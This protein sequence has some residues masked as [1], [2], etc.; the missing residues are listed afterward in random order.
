[1]FSQ[2]K[3]YCDG[4]L[5]VY[6]DDLECVIPF[7]ELTV[8]P[9]TLSQGTSIFARLTAVNEI[10]ESVPSDAGNGA[11]LFI[12]SVPD[13]PVGLAREAVTTTTTQIGLLW[14]P[15]SSDG[16]QPVIDYRIWY[17]EGINNFVILADSVNQ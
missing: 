4:S 12:S 8:A 7:A 9:Y 6:L 5:Q 11:T 13:A 3:D 1:V 15:G 16:G 17:D 2:N 10:G 14:N